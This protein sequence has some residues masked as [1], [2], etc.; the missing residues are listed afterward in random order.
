MYI[1][2][3]RKFLEIWLQNI[4][5]SVN[6]WIVQLAIN[7]HHCLSFQTELCNIICDTS[8]L[9]VRKDDDLRLHFFDYS[10]ELSE[11]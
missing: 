10:S 7:N 8:F 2:Y 3:T 6:G 5:A 9:V 1:H 11:F 4:C